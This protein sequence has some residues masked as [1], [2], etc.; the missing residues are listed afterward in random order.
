MNYMKNFKKIKHKKNN[1]YYF[2]LPQRIDNV[3][4]IIKELII[5]EGIGGGS[6]KKTYNIK[7]DS[8]YYCKVIKGIVFNRENDFFSRWVKYRKGECFRR[9][10]NKP[11]PIG[12]LVIYRKSMY[13]II[14]NT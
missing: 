7:K 10:F 11:Q 5:P 14:R 8:E 1:L 9:F 2:R 6:S 4:D 12:K 13:R 3:I